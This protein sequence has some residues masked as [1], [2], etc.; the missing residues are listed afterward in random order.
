MGNW[1]KVVF[2]LL[3]F[4]IGLPAGVVY[5]Q[6]N[7]LNLLPKDRISGAEL[8]ARTD[9]RAKGRTGGGVWMV[10]RRADGT[11]VHYWN[12]SKVG[13]STSE[14]KGDVRYVT[15]SNGRKYSCALYRNPSGSKEAMNEFIADCS[16]GVF[17]HSR[18]P[19]PVPGSN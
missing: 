7:K 11:A 13:T 5:A 14:I 2:W 12:G 18:S 19:M 10:D 17:P 9:S 4:G 3:L 6:D 8:R 16:H 1:T 15:R